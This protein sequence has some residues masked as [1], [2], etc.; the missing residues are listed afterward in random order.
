MIYSKN[1]DIIFRKI[2][3]EFVLVPIRQKVVD[4]KSIYTLNESAAF[5]WELMDGA[6][7]TIEIKDKLSQEFEIEA[8][9][10]EADIAELVSQ[11]E[12]LTLIR[13]V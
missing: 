12:A 9:A 10:A 3:D 5:I 13:K 8:S 4:L 7:D 6:R 11:L 2:A 1:P